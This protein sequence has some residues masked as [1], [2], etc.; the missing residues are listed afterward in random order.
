[1]GNALDGPAIIIEANST[2]VIEPG[3]SARLTG[4]NHLVLT[5]IS[6]LARMAAVGTQVD[7]VRLEI[8]NN[9]F[10]SIAEQMGT[11]L[12]KTSHSVNIKERLDFSCAIFDARGELVAN[13]PHIPVHLGS[14]G[15]SVQSV[16]RNC[17]QTMRPGDA[18]VINAPYNGGTHLPDI[19]VITPVYDDAGEHILLYVGSRGHHADIGGLTPGSMPPNSSSI[20]QEG[21]L[22]DNFKLLDAGQFCEMELRTLL[23]SNRYP[24]RNPDQNV[25]DLKAQIA[26]NEAGVQGLRKMIDHF[27]LAT[28]RAFM[29]HVQNNA[30]ESIRRVIDDLQDGSFT[31]PFDDGTVVHVSI[32]IDKLKRQARIDF[33][34]ILG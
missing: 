20:E 18:Y 4:R 23:A 11:T 21:V 31:Y 5:R 34:G 26:A 19:T 25:A 3:W 15:E 24:A 16:I 10:M 9:L 17:A 14:M 13:A 12:Q 30:E 33:C 27:S 28:V 1:M 32:S 7:P 6:A 2:I 22:F 29:D 8:F